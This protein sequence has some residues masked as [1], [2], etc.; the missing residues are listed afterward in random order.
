ME[1]ET[2]I[3]LPLNRGASRQR[4]M[5]QPQ[6]CNYSHDL[7]TNRAFEL[8]KNRVESYPEQPFFLYLAWTLPH[9]GGWRGII[10]DGE[11]V[12]NNQPFDNTTWPTVEQEQ[13]K[14]EL[15]FIVKYVDVAEIQH[16]Q[17]YYF[18][19]SLIIVIIM[20]ELT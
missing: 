14:F 9:A 13:E 6:T 10:E 16:V 15:H 2:Q 8:I 19:I 7:F 12:P 11:P 1:N 5:S 4:C 20:V 18:N 17:Q 3:P